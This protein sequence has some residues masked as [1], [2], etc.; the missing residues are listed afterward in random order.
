MQFP[1][2]LTKEV[3]PPGKE[4]DILIAEKVMGWRRLTYAQAN[5]G[6][7]NY[8]G[9]MRLTPHWYDEQL[10]ETRLA[11]D[12]YDYYQPEEAWSP[13]TNIADAWDVVEKLKYFEIQAPNAPCN[14]GE[15]ANHSTD[16]AVELGLAPDGA[17][18]SVFARG[19]SAPHA[20]CLAS[21]KAVEK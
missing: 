11:E 21:L 1:T 6:N 18:E 12:S 2:P 19:I 3:P 9:D 8:A 7:K 10:S 14:G 20:I 16:W 13:S 5:P 4:L 15:Y 17:E